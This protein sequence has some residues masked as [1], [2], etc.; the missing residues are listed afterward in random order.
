M[1]RFKPNDPVFILTKFA[2]LYPANSAVVIAVEADPFRPMFNEYT[3]EFADRSTAKIFEFQM[4][5]DLANYQTLL[6]NLAFDSWKQSHTTHTRG[7]P[8]ERELILQTTGFDVAMKIRTNNSR[9]SIIGQVLERGTK[10]LLKNLE[11]RLMKEAMPISATTSDSFGI[12][13]FSDPPRGQCYPACV[14]VL[15]PTGSRTS[16]PPSSPFAQ[17]W[18]EF[19]PDPKV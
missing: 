11:I 14:W 7:V 15:L 17:A 8:A 1:E 2:H 5:E 18:P 9:A 4:I 12:F 16:A 10:S 3:V 6:A 13:K 19:P